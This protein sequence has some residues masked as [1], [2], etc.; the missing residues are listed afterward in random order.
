MQI[1]L[2]V[3][4]TLILIGSAAYW[5]LYQ[6]F[7]LRR[8]ITVSGNNRKPLYSPACEQLRWDVPS[9]FLFLTVR[10]IPRTRFTRLEA[11]LQ[12]WIKDA[13]ELNSENGKRIVNKVR[14]MS[15]SRLP[16]DRQQNFSKSFI[17]YNTRDTVLES[18]K[19]D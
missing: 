10:T 3:S 7:G 6:S 5:S 14:I 8:A 9:D 18:R 11:S 4:I 13:V 16:Y 1:W 19:Q 12:T 2:L 17:R 15:D